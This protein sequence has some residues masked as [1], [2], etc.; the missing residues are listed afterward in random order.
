VAVA[1][2]AVVGAVLSIVLIGIPILLAAGLAGC[3]IGVWFVVRCI[4]GLVHV[5]RGDA[6]P[7]PEALLA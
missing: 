5:S 3:V 4:V 6:Y 2:A 1:A 7:R